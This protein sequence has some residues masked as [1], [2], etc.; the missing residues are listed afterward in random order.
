MGFNSIYTHPMGTFSYTSPN[1][2]IEKKLR[3]MGW[4]SRKVA[5]VG[6]K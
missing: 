5:K 2:F 3:E 1:I 6:K 4:V